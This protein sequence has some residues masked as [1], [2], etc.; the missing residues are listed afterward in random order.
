MEDDINS[1]MDLEIIIPK[2]ETRY[3][4]KCIQLCKDKRNYYLNK[5]NTKNLEIGKDDNYFEYYNKLFYENF[6]YF[7][8]EELFNE[9]NNVYL[10]GKFNKLKN[11]NVINKENK[12][13]LFKLNFERSKM[14]LE[15]VSYGLDEFDFKIKNEITYLELDICKTIIDIIK[16]C[17]NIKEFNLNY[18]KYEYYKYLKNCK[19]LEGEK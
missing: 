15:L 8:D 16:N 11:I 13:I 3:I 7:L 2:D 4:Q 12:N 19:S 18:Q 17:I 9:F 10:Y 6:I 5:Y 1:E 14:I